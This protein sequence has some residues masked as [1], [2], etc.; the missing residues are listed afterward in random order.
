MKVTST[1]FSVMTKSLAGATF[2]T[3]QGPGICVRQKAAPINPNTTLQS[4]I[5][6]SWSGASQLWNDLSNATREQWRLYALTCSVLGEHGSYFLTGRQMFM[7]VMS[8]T[9]HLDL[10]GVPMGDVDTD[11]PVE[12]GWLNVVNV[13]PIDPVGVAVTGI[14]LTFESTGTEGIVGWAERSFAFRPARNRFKGP[15]I[16]SSLSS[17]VIA[18]PAS[19]V[20]EF[21]GLEED[22]I[23]FTRF[24][25]I[26]EDAPHRISTPFFLRHVGY[27][28]PV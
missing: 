19:G 20:I 27:V 25:A 12:P 8:T 26:T 7:A 2:Y 23:Y 18:A 5:R 6:S 24:R 22:M 11:P 3:G 1:M 16:A 15:M 14:A 17:A 10:Q 9:L 21:E 4:S 13:A 28:V